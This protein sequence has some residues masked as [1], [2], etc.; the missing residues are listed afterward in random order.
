MNNQ[1]VI[2]STSTRKLKKLTVKGKKLATIRHG[3]AC[4]LTNKMSK[5]LAL[6]VELKIIMQARLYPWCILSDLG[7]RVLTQEPNLCS[8]E[9]LT[10][11]PC[12]SVVVV[13][14]KRRVGRA[15]E[16]STI[17]LFITLQTDSAKLWWI[18]D[19][20]LM[21]RWLC[22]WRLRTTRSKWIKQVHLWRKNH[23]STTFLKAPQSVTS[24]PK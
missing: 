4:D 6:Q 13:Q 24:N 14:N 12:H 7:H 18:T 10:T 17:V 2:K 8:H 19:A 3:N 15:V 21:K 23:S 1:K 20:K 11:S 9:T 5:K 22:L 16:I